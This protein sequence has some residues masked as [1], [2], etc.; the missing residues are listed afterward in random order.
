MTQHRDNATR[1]KARKSALDIVYES[2]L[3][4]R[5]LAQTLAD[6]IALGPVRPFTIE[7]VNGVDAHIRELDAVLAASLAGS[8]TLERM[9]RLDR[10]LARL[11]LYEIAHT[12]TPAPVAIKEAV[13]LAAK[14]STPD[15]PAFL[16][17]VLSAAAGRLAASGSDQ[18]Q[19]NA[20]GDPEDE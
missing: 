7:L 20:L 10:N 11:A 5:A 1:T 12:D 8:W 15:S 13:D 18:N 9:A 4:D 19:D 2:E 17:A 6:R 3:R 16:N 14:L